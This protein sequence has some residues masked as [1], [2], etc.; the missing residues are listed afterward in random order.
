MPRR[1]VDARMPDQEP[2]D[3]MNRSS[4]QPA[5]GPL[6][7]LVALLASAE[8]GDWQRLYAESD[9][10][11][12]DFR[13]LGAVAV[14]REVRRWLEA[15]SEAGAPG[16]A[17]PELPA[18]QRAIEDDTATAADVYTV[19]FGSP[20]PLPDE[21][22]LQAVEVALK[23]DARTLIGQVLLPV[24]AGALLR[25]GDRGVS[26]FLDRLAGHAEALKGAVAMAPDFRPL[27]DLDFEVAPGVDVAPVLAWLARQGPPGLAPPS[28]KW[29][30][31]SLI[32][33]ADALAEVGATHLAGRVK[34][35][36][37]AMTL[38]EV[39]QHPLAEAL[40]E[41]AR[42]GATH[43]EYTGEPP[44][45]FAYWVRV[46]DDAAVTRLA[47][48]WLAARDQ[49]D[50][51]ALDL[52]L[53][54]PAVADLEVI[55]A[56]LIGS[57]GGA[58]SD[59]SAEGSGANDL[60][61]LVRDV[62][63]ACDGL[64]HDVSESLVHALLASDESLRAAACAQ[65]DAH[66]DVIRSMRTRPGSM[67]AAFVDWFDQRAT[68]YADSVNRGRAPFDEWAAGITSAWQREGSPPVAEPDVVARLI[69][70]H[71][72]P[73]PLQ[74]VLRAYADDQKER[75]AVVCL[76]AAL[77]LLE[78]ATRGGL[79]DWGY[80]LTRA[81]VTLIGER[82]WLPMYPRRLALLDDVVEE[83][84]GAELADLLY[85]R[86]LT[87]SA[88]GDVPGALED[89]ERAAIE[90]LHADDLEQALAVRLRW[91]QFMLAGSDLRGRSAVVGLVENM[92]SQLLGLE[93]NAHQR[94]EVFAV[95]ARCAMAAG[96]DDEAIARHLGCLDAALN[97]LE[98]GNE[99]VLS[100]A[101]RAIIRSRRG[102]LAGASADAKAALAG[103]DDK[104]DPFA[105]SRAYAA[106]VGVCREPGGAPSAEAIRHAR[107]ALDCLISGR[108]PVQQIEDA[109]IELGQIYAG[110]GEVVDAEA[111]FEEAARRAEQGA[112]V[113]TEAEARRRRAML[114]LATGDAEE[115]LRWL[116]TI[117]E[118]LRPHLD[119]QE[120]RL[121][122]AQASAAA[123]R[124]VDLQTL[125]ADAVEGR[126]DRR[127]AMPR[128]RAIYYARPET[129]WSAAVHRAW[130]DLLG[131]P[132]VTALVG[133]D[134]RALISL[135]RRDEAIERLE[136]AW[137]SKAAPAEQ[138][139]IAVGILRAL[140]SDAFEPRTRWLEVFE[141]HLD[142][143]AVDGHMHCDL[144]LELGRH[145]RH[146]RDVDMLRRAR[147]RAR[148]AEGDAAVRARALELEADARADLIVLQWPLST[149]AVVD[150]ARWFLDADLPEAARAALV[151]RL[152]DSLLRPGPL[153][154]AD[155]LTL[156]EQL[157]ARLGAEQDERR[158]RIGWI[159]A[160]RR[161]EVPPADA[162]GADP[163][164]DSAPNWVVE[165]ATGRAV[166]APAAEVAAGAMLLQVFQRCRPDLTDAITCRLIELADG[167]APPVA[168]ALHDAAAI[169]LEFAETH[170]VELPGVAALV[171]QGRAPAL[172]ES[173]LRRVRPGAG[174]RPR[175]ESR[176]TSP[177]ARVKLL[178]AE[179]VRL[180]HAAAEATGVAQ[181]Q[182]AEQAARLLDE[183]VAICR[184]HPRD[185]GQWLHRCLL[186]AGDARK[187]ASPPDVETG[188]TLL[189]EA[190]KEASRDGSLE[191][192][193]VRAQH[194]KCI[195]DV[196]AMRGRPEDF[197][198]AE[199]RIERALTLR[200]TGA[201]RAATLVMAAQ[202]AQ[203]HPERQT[204][205][206][207]GRGARYIIEAMELDPRARD[208]GR[209]AV[210]LL[211]RWCGARPQPSSA[212]LWAE[213][214]RAL[215]VLAAADI[216]QA[217]TGMHEQV[218]GAS[219]AEHVA[220]LVQSEAME[221]FGRYTMGLG[222]SEDFVEMAESLFPPESLEMIRA[223][224]RQSVTRWSQAGAHRAAIDEL[225]ALDPLT[226]RGIGARAAR[227]CILADWLRRGGPVSVEAIRGVTAEVRGALRT[228]PDNVHA[229]ILSVIASNF[230]PRDHTDD[231]VRDFALAA[232][233]YRQVIAAVGEDSPMGLEC[234][235]NM[236]RA[237]RYRT[238]GDIAEHLA[239]ARRLFERCMAI[240]RRIG[241]VE[242]L[243]KALENLAE[244]DDYVGLFDHE[245]RAERSIDVLRQRVRQTVGQESLANQARL[246]WAL[247][248]STFRRPDE[249]A[250]PRLKE[251]ESLFSGCVDAGYRDPGNLALNYTV[252]RGELAAREGRRP[253]G[254]L[255]WRSYLETV[256]RDLHPHRWATGAHNLAELLLG[257]GPR[258][259]TRAILD[260]AFGLYTEALEGRS[261][262]TFPRHAWETLFAFGS[263]LVTVAG[264]RLD[265]V[266]APPG[267]IV[268]MGL[269]QL[270]KAVEIGRELGAGHEMLMAAHRMAQ[271][272]SLSPHPAALE[273]HGAILHD[274]L[275]AGLTAL[276]VDEGSGQ[277][278]SEIAWIM[279]YGASSHDFV[280]RS[281]DS[282][283]GIEWLPTDVEALARRWWPRF[284]AAMHRRQIAARARPTA[285]PWS[286]WHDWLGA[287]DRRDAVDL[288]RC[289]DA[290]R[291]ADPD[292]LTEEHDW[293]ATEAWL[294]ER[295]ASAVIAMAGARDRLLA[296][297]VDT[298]A[299]RTRFRMAAL[300]TAGD[301][302]R[303]MSG[304]EGLAWARAQ[305]A[306][307]R[308]LM[309]ASG[310]LPSHVLWCPSGPLREMPPEV[311]WPGAAV[312]VAS[313]PMLLPRPA[314]VRPRRTLLVAADPTESF[315]DEF[316][317]A[318]GDL[319]ELTGPDTRVL[320]SQGCR[321]GE[322]LLVG[323][324][325]TAA[326]PDE[327]LRWIGEYDLLILLAH[328]RMDGGDE[329]FIQLQSN[330]G[331]VAEL[332][333][334][335]VARNDGLR[336]ASVMLLS[337]E[338][339]QIGLHQH[340]PGGLAG[341]FLAAGAS[342]VMAPL[343]SVG[344]R[345][346]T[347][348][349]EKVVQIYRGGGVRLSEALAASRIGESAA[350]EGGDAFVVWTA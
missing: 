214:L 309:S 344:F 138:V 285:V 12:V 223:G 90:A 147:D 331:A 33:A 164:F 268:F 105:R 321:H 267:V 129:E 329:A 170:P 245:A 307:L 276:L 335:D 82:G 114:A 257:G 34:T 22:L 290:V 266:D 10:P 292:F 221:T 243:N 77:S 80:P 271:G 97:F 74:D 19:F 251:A 79:S 328:G 301:D 280:R 278:E 55:E 76:V 305:T 189:R 300:Y 197:R 89:L 318:I 63:A 43:V 235:G 11:P 59:G 179:G 36:V 333:V 120:L 131:L 198:E 186:S 143:V 7:R 196:L 73:E 25:G 306:R 175:S 228:L 110:R 244:L 173:V 124:A 184:A 294:G 202:I 14:S 338:T 104:T 311:L 154:T 258:E 122:R 252:C 190:E 193:E 240:A 106:M 203:R 320:I 316:R 100:F 69:A 145:A 348:L 45:L 32:R 91:A 112:A 255:L 238:D 177:V 17:L 282:R 157:L 277:A 81:A 236:A 224:R 41:A 96:E 27:C 192:P 242:S 139:S 201:V 272:V 6:A 70:A 39:A 108:A 195:A 293:S 232:D 162:L 30:E 20:E 256:D 246:A 126:L 295:P 85:R 75:P 219:L 40:R 140:P 153:A 337:C 98:P 204:P 151:P 288:Q 231:P 205:E 332:R 26:A 225:D 254:V 325:P 339:G 314:R 119:P 86:G 150:E 222:A 264:H 220:S 274:A 275:E 167:A 35:M 226:A 291:S 327:A 142:G 208:F 248:A 111:C 95:L 163:S 125:L 349:A 8:P 60:I 172:V 183:A 62:R 109:R 326:S 65:L 287:V 174:V 178:R 230:A 304:P 99:R 269:S 5:T 334:A 182:F 29:D 215:D 121:L 93:L 161:G 50:S 117:R 250:L 206:G 156:A 92:V 262:E 83:A 322:A 207:A 212:R 52:L 229:R 107:R 28:E 84:D 234:L 270:Q 263:K 336:G 165:L 160:R 241:A 199:T 134:A 66:A 209:L 253:D 185:A 284:Y 237:T 211:A 44:A 187:V 1:R 166:S 152:V 21:R 188:L 51:S 115:A 130:L 71:P 128:L 123:G 127:A 347:R 259:W 53:A 4:N 23:V 341:A 273:R 57:M 233:L 31:G 169:A 72:P 283:V 132:D 113:R 317:I 216:D 87:R 180:S 58:P 141:T 249:H 61:G 308:A 297:I 260:E 299:G 200:R 103:C 286:T 102:D 323:A 261:R 149:T 137:S 144:A 2:E 56:Q 54:S 88:L 345:P 319:R 68:S 158:W 148:Q 37:I 155:A 218:L 18:A 118:A 101:Q 181:N 194:D 42:T 312:V 146:R 135:D 315:D 9:C 49:R 116:D 265:L 247:T 24:M 350:D 279:L 302:P 313:S 15:R 340:R 94:G 213:R 346:A 210:G 48:R 136:S 296:L 176:P 342:E 298:D 64:P 78:A 324:E 159:A 217:L 330:N 191:H 303:D 3:Q 289:L 281:P 343:T 239:E 13:A 47:G 38:G 171:E 67:L 168:E 227:V 16:Q 310:V 133:D 46:H